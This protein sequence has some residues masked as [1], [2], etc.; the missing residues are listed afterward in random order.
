MQNCCKNTGRFSDLLI[1]TP[2]MRGVRNL[3]LA[4]CMFPWRCRRNF[5]SKPAGFAA[6]L[7]S[8]PFLEPEPHASGSSGSSAP[9]SV[10]SFQQENVCT[11]CHD[12]M[13][14]HVKTRI[15]FKLH[16]PCENALTPTSNGHVGCHV[17]VPFNPRQ[18]KHILGGPASPAAS[19]GFAGP[20]PRRI[21]LNP[22]NLVATMSV[23]VF[24]G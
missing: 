15:S 7:N 16:N 5:I 8:R 22:T 18:L 10:P 11:A 19:P 3:M 21:D 1:T 17:D 9:D 23:Q 6:P 4:A 13:I 14:F 2:N 12:S 24:W 20:C